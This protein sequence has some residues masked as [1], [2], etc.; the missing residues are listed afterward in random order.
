MLLLNLVVSIPDQDLVQSRGIA[1]V[2]ILLMIGCAV[3]VLFPI[4]IGV[5]AVKSVMKP[6]LL[7][8]LYR[9][10]RT[11]N[12]LSVVTLTMPVEWNV[13][14]VNVPKVKKIDRLFL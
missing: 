11:G 7:E 2:Q 13:I 1:K 6:V 12:A 9:G 3:N 10:L 4:M 14:V 8:V 5:T